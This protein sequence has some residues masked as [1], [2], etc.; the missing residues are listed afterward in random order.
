MKS[1]HLKT[2]TKL[3]NQLFD[4][5][6]DEWWNENG[7]F[8]ALHSYNLIRLKY[9]IENVNKTSLSKLKILD[10]GCG[11]GILCE[12][13][14]RLGADVTG[15]DENKKAIEVAKSHSKINKLKINYRNINLN[16]ITNRSFDVITCMEVLEHV[17]DINQIISNSAHLLKSGGIFIGSTINKT[18]SSYLFAIFAAEK[19][20]KIVP[21]K[22]HS[23]E[24]LVKPNTL[25]VDFLKNGFFNFNYN[26]VIYNPLTNSWRHSSLTN[27]NYMFYA[28]KA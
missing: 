28:F 15:V 8:K 6:S 9:I 12:P 10:V 11:G 2:T 16:Q 1:K 17:D 25:K 24:K 23:W 7:P 26:G 13:L 3:N 19:I 22:T 20:L 5:L 18:F 27:I 21:E 4:S 14:A